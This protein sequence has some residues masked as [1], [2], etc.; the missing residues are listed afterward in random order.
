ML[1]CAYINNT[2]SEF[3]SC[4]KT[5]HGWR[6]TTHCL[7]PSFEQVSVF[8]RG[9]GDGF[10]ITDAGGAI[11]NVWHHGIDHS[12]A[13]RAMIKAAESF[14]CE[15]LRKEISLSVKTDEWL[16][17]GIVSVANASSEA[18]R[19]V[20]S[21][22]RI[23]NESGLIQKT[24]RFLEG[25]SWQPETKLEHAIHG[26]SGKLHTFDLA[27][28][29]ND[30]TGLIDAVVPHANSIAAKYL[31]FADTESRAGLYKYAIFD[32]ELTS[33]DKSLISDVADLVSYENV[34]GTDGKFLL[35]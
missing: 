14:G 33:E 2:L 4:E 32:T 6:V 22:T 9:Y 27:V 28:F 20:V 5:E 16:Y 3:G 30:S 10:V 26:S 17:S 25:L 23:A 1:D 7:Y 18:A 24:K 11:T 13:Q 21:K 29:H 15:Y 8:V 12:H 19:A 34:I 35:Q 31:A